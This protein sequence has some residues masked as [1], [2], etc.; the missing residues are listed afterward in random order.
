LPQEQVAANQRE[1][2]LAA[3]IDVTHE[4]GY[5]AIKITDILRRS[6]VSRTSFYEL[7]DNREDCL[8]TAYDTQVVQAEAEI[9]S[10]YRN[11]RLKDSERLAAAL[12]R[13]FEIVV[14]WPAAARLCTSEIDT[15]GASGWQ[16]SNQTLDLGARALN[17]ALSQISGDSI[18]P[19]ITGAIV[20]GLRRLI[21]TR[22]R[23][24]REQE[25]LK[26][27]DDVLDWMLIYSAPASEEL[28][29][30]RPTLSEAVT[31]PGLLAESAAANEGGSANQ[32]MQ[33]HRIQILAGVAQVIAEKG[34]AAMGYRDIAAAAQI[35]LT[36]FYNHFTSK[37]EAVLALS[38]VVS[39]HYSQIV[40]RAFRASSDP[41]SALRDAITD[42]LRAIAGD[43]TGSRLA[44]AE[45]LLLGRP[46]VERVDAA[47]TRAQSSLAS[48]AQLGSDQSGLMCELIVGALSELVRRKVI[49]ARLEDL[50]Q[51]APAL[52][53]VALVPLIGSDLA[54]ELAADSP[55]SQ[56]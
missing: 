15:A 26:M 54:R 7:F 44:A 6:S 52:S 19:I 21:Y 46:G 24:E 42:L 56:P 17:T 40:M 53:Y 47:L 29:L 20:G 22:V 34:Y 4:R 30:A 12:L 14:S 8:L 43:P 18:P 25:L 9:I 23:D 51:L 48:H 38:D 28:P 35:S 27:A 2:L 31:L 37:Q 10:A 41:P 39:N 55:S 50:P 33:A 49:E 1:R 5:P 36:T 11:P 16:S 45:I 13:L 3:M 32:R